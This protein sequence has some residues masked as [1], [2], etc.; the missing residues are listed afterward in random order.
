MNMLQ[1]DIAETTGKL[2][3]M[4]SA[5]EIYRP[6]DEFAERKNYVS[7]SSEAINHGTRNG[8]SYSYGVFKP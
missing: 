4:A 5:T 8:K 2:N 7:F 3:I 1:R 6:R